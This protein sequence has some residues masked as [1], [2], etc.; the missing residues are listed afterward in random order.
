ML[1]LKHDLIYYISGLTCI[2]TFSIIPLFSKYL[3]KSMDNIT[4]SYLVYMVRAVPFIIAVLINNYLTNDYF[5]LNYNLAEAFA[6]DKIFL[7][8][9]ESIRTVFIILAF[10]LLPSSIA[11][12]LFF[13]YPIMILL[14][15]HYML[16]IPLTLH[17][18]LG[19][20]IGLIGVVVIS[21]TTEKINGWVF[22]VGALMALTAA[23]LEAYV[24]VYL[25]KEDIE[26]DKS[27]YDII[28]E[29]AN[30]LTFG[31]VLLTVLYLVYLTI[32]NKS[33][34]FKPNFGTFP[35][36]SISFISTITY[37][38]GLIGID[39][40]IF[41]YIVPFSIVLLTIIFETLFEKKPMTVK[42]IV[43]ILF[44]IIGGVVS[45]ISPAHPINL[46]N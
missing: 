24:T 13:S 23:A 8:T 44:I 14:L 40:N 42:N 19:G 21:Y 34:Y 7:S 2:V 31:T 46:T 18:V 26:N 22:I 38:I 15:N 33:I 11:Q 1:D 30:F 16:N 17:A 12:S 39:P 36:L 32:F 28:P 6:L 27:A 10:I 45:L 29:M 3:T 25:K 43:G 20:L 5:K 41:A 35:I 9:L 4:Q 37:F